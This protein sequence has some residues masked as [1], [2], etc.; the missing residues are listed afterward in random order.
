MGVD[1]KTRRPVSLP[2]LL[3]LVECGQ[4]D[5]Y[6]IA[7]ALNIE[8]CPFRSALEE[9]ALEESRSLAGVLSLPGHQLEVAQELGV[10]FDSTHLFATLV[11]DG[12]QHLGESRLTQT[13][14]GRFLL[15]LELERGSYRCRSVTSKSTTSRL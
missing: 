8:E 4:G 9:V 15:L 3:Q 2:T 10:V 5:Q 13:L 1:E 6:G 12:S 7:D 14:P 11:D